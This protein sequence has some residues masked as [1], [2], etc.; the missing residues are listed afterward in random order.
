MECGQ[1]W[2]WSLFLRQ[3]GLLNEQ[4]MTQP[5]GKQDAG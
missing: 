5:D 4:E 1:L 3:G 2:I